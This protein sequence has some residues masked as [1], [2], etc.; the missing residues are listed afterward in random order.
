MADAALVLIETVHVNQTRVVL[1]KSKESSSKLCV[2]VLAFTSKGDG[3]ASSCI[4]V[5]SWSEGK[6]IL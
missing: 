4:E 5:W 1:N 3:Q 6:L 2:R